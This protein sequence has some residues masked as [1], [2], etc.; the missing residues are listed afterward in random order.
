MDTKM[1]KLIKLFFSAWPVVLYSVVCS[2]NIPN[3]C[4]NH[5]GFVK[6]LCQTSYVTKFAIRPV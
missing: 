6:I 5:F 4:V 2:I 3:V 1:Y